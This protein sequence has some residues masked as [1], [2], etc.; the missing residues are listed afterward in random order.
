LWLPMGCCGLVHLCSSAVVSLMS[1]CTYCIEC[2]CARVIPCLCPRLCLCAA[3]ALGACWDCSPS[4]WSFS[5]QHM[6]IRAKQHLLRNRS[7][8]Y[9]HQDGGRAWS[10][11]TAGCTTRQCRKTCDKDSDQLPIPKSSHHPHTCTAEQHTASR[12][13]P[14]SRQPGTRSPLLPHI[15]RPHGMQQA[16]AKV[17]GNSI[18]PAYAKLSLIR[19]AAATG[20]AERPPQPPHRPEK[21]HRSQQMPW[22]AAHAAVQ[23]LQHAP[24]C[25]GKP[26][27]VVTACWHT[28]ADHRAAAI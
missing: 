9:R 11:A 6:H 15:A 24:D 1:V 23:R 10:H 7:G 20:A 28:G 12:A 2:S 16:P 27:S 18:Y 25:K 21:H 4:R 22:S 14:A 5:V 3:E 26:L 8:T 17:P 13:A 19:Q